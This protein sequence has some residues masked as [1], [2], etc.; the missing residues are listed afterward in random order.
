MVGLVSP[1]PGCPT[2]SLAAESTPARASVAAQWWRDFGDET[3][4]GQLDLTRQRSTPPTGRHD[5]GSGGLAGPAAVTGGGE[6]HWAGGPGGFSA[7]AFVVFALLL[8]MRLNFNVQ[9]DFAT[10]MIPTINQGVAMVFFFIPLVTSTLSGISPG[11]IPDA[12]GLSNFVR[13]TAGSFG[14]S[15]ATTIWQDRAAMH[16]AQIS[17]YVNPGSAATS[18]ALSGLAGAGLTHEQAL[19]II[20][21]MANQQA[22]MLAANDVFYVS[23]LIFLALIPLV[24]LTQ[25][26]KAGASSA[27]AA[28]GAH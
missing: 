2:A 28:A 8:W 26:D 12:S 5:H 13:I 11:R 17:E 24:Y 14:A 9:A 10:I 3:P 25:H 15:I 19:G 7:F 20:D 21:R 22:Y 23:A 1:G 27:D 18:S 16:H 6:K 4:N